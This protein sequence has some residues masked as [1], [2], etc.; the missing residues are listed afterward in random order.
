MKAT[1]LLIMALVVVVPVG[2]VVYREL[3]RYLKNK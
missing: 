3:W 1:I 2:I